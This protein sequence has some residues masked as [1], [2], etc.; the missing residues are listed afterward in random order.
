MIGL[1]E[2]TPLLDVSEGGQV[3]SPNENKRRAAA[4]RKL[5]TTPPKS[6]SNVIIVSHKPNLQNAAGKEFGDLGEGEIVVFQP[7]DG[8]EVHVIARVPAADWAAAGK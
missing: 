8:G 7:A 6:G 3:V 5:L 2:V 1:G 4:L